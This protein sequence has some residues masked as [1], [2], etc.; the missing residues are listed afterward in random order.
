[1]PGLALTSVSSLRRDLGDECTVLRIHGNRIFAGS[2]EGV[3]AC[4]MAATGEKVWEA[5]LAGPISSLDFAE[6]RVYVA[7]SSMVHCVNNDSG[8]IVWSRE[9]EGSSDY[10]VV[11]DGVWATSSVYEIEIGD[12]TESTIWRFDGAGELQQRW[13]IAER[14]WFIGS[15]ESGLVLGL[16]RPRCGALRL[17]DGELGHLEIPDAGPVT[18]GTVAGNRILLGHSDGKVSEV[19]GSDCGS[20]LEG[21]SPVS[22][23][24]GVENETIV[25]LEHGMVV[26]SAGWSHS[27]GGAVAALSLGPWL[28]S[29]RVVWISSGHGVSVVH[30]DGGNPLL[31]L[32]HECRITESD[33]NGDIIVLGDSQGAIHLVERDVLSR[34]LE[35]ET[36]K[37]DDD[38]KKKEMMDRLRGLRGR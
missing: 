27:S 9:L 16:G 24:L 37:S 11:D 36:D 3:L 13:T 31:E 28:S 5:S 29:D 8:E 14:C 7:E 30:Q 25:G 20:A 35:Q 4:W 2:R 17:N 10:V 19:D 23:V 26:S 18:C 6:D 12:Y 15:D 22:A 21:E 1:M 38:A 34:R 32:V 33:S